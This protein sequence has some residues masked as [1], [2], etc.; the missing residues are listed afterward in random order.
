M[1]KSN[2]KEIT[3]YGNKNVETVVEKKSTYGKVSIVIAG[4]ELGSASGSAGETIVT[5]GSVSEYR[6]TSR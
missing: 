2:S 3:P 4:A 6:G 5:S 1:I